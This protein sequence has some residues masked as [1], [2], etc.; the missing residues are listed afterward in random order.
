MTLPPDTAPTPR[1]PRLLRLS[2]RGRE[3]LPPEAERPVLALGNFDG[4][5]RGHRAVIAAGRALADAAG[6]P[7]WL[8]SFDPHPRHFF[9]REAPAF[10]LTPPDWKAALAARLGADGLILHA[11]DADFAALSAS[12][13]L[14]EVLDARLRA[15]GV[16]VG[17]GF[18]FGARQSGDAD[19]LR[20]WARAGGHRLA[21]VP[22]TLRDGQRVSSTAI[23]A[24]LAAGDVAGANDC[25]GYRFVLRGPVRHGDKRGRDLG[26]PTANLTLPEGFGLRHGIYAVRARIEGDAPGRLLDGVASFGRRPTFDNGAPLFET[27]LF[28]FAGDLY[29]RTLR[30]ELVGWIR[31]EERFDSAD[32]LIAR[33]HEDARAARALLAAA[34]DAALGP[35]APESHLDAPMP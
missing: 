10:D 35:D 9:G 23:R 19:G 1:I 14:R 29:G 18:R 30:L 21:I 34:R 15:T 33:M 25:L 22:P 32:A 28:D 8:M 4:L 16:A 12:D 24:A 6:R 3:A 31:P 2:L 5:H 26:F 7:L 13:F 11:F 27:F 17:E 20:A